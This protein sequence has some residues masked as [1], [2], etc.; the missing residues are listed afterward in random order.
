[1]AGRP[2]VVALLTDFG[3]SDH[4]VGTL[5]AVI[6][7]DAPGTQIVDL[8][9]SV[10]P[11]DVRTAAFQLRSSYR[12]HPP[13]TLF[14]CV[15]DPGVGSDRKILY[16]EAGR[17]RFLA[18]D[19]GLL[20]WTFD[21]VPPTLLLDV[22]L[23]PSRTI[24]RTFHGRDVMAPVAARLLNGDSPTSLGTAMPDCV[25]IPFPAV[26]KRGGMWRGQV[27]AVDTYGN[28]ITNLRSAELAPLAAHSKLWFD[29]V[30]HKASIR[31]MAPTY[32]SVDEGRLLAT[33]GSS[34]FIEIA[35]RNGNAA[36]VTGLKSGDP[37]VANFLT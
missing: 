31:G 32:A 15:V 29:L 23:P 36:Q 5:K 17:W 19:N 13:E 22:S 16:A 14:V 2:G 33:E 4:Y 11:Q 1:M 8:T 37:V 12:F 35:V 20:S 6:L 25:R 24:S 26:E 18:P 27:V 21:E 30:S 7:A 3:L 10:P 34:G 9:H 28:L